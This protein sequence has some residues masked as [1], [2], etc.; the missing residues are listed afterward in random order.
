VLSWLSLLRS[1]IP[2]FP[3][4]IC[5]VAIA[6]D[7]PS[8]RAGSLRWQRLVPSPIPRTRCTSGSFNGSS[9]LP[10][11]ALPSF[12]RSSAFPSQEMV[13]P[14]PLVSLLNLSFGYTAVHA[15]TF[16]RWLLYRLCLNS[17]QSPK[18]WFV[19]MEML[20]ELNDLSLLL[21]QSPRIVI[22][23]I[24]PSL[25]LCQKLSMMNH[26]QVPNAEYVYTDALE[27]IKMFTSE[28]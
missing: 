4:F 25:L 24:Y 7:S 5:P 8:H 18:M 27:V 23:S 1:P 15:S 22:E 11:L 28:Q 21:I 9:P 10:S 19:S 20:F 13:R 16:S 14:S 12:L 3:L 26:R 2:D 17:L 6:S